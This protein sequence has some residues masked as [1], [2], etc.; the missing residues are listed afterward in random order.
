MRVLVCGGRDFF[1]RA[2]LYKVLDRLHKKLIFDTLMEGNARG[3]DKL[4]GSWA[5]KNQISLLIYHA[6][7]RN[8][9]RAAGSVRNRKMLEEGKPNLVVAF[10]GGT[11]TANMVRISREAG[12]D[13]VEV[14]Y[15]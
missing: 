4:A 14:S 12:I 2:F 11:G 1:R 10:P 7:W 6:E 13:I 9:G 3:A 15:A 5:R 8:Y